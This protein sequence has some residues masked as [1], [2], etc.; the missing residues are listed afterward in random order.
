MK[1]YRTGTK[2]WFIYEYYGVSSKAYIIGNGT[3][4][5]HYYVEKDD[6]YPIY[7]INSLDLYPQGI[8]GEQL[9]TSEQEAYEALEVQDPKTFNPIRYP[10]G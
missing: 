6:L 2:V 5:R 3:I 9:F 4:I 10:K 7:V 8:P 1:E